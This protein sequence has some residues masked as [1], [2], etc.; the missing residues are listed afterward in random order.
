VAAGGARAAA[1]NSSDRI[2]PSRLKSE[3]KASFLAMISAPL[4]SNPFFRT[5]GELREASH[6][7]LRRVWRKMRLQVRIPQTSWRWKWPRNQL[8]RE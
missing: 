7:G 2:A 8:L 5:I 3:P 4:S 6:A 1:I